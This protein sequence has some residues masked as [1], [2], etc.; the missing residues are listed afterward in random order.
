MRSVGGRHRKLGV[1]VNA[2]FGGLESVD[3]FDVLAG[4]QRAETAD[5]PVSVCPEAH[6]RA[7]N[8]VVARAF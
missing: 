6:V 1:A 3:E 8:M 7:V 5:R 4:G 2:Q